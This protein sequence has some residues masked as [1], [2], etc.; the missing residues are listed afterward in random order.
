MKKLFRTFLLTV[1]L[2]PAAFAQ[3]S[4][5]GRVIEA[6]DGRTIVLETSAG[7]ITAQVKN[8]EL[9]EPNQPLFAVT[10]DCLSKLVG[11]KF[12]E[13]KLSRLD[14]GTTIGR[15]MV[16]GVDLSLQMIRDGAAWHEPR[17]TSAHTKA[18]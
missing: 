6:I 1:L 8:L 9:P 17:E 7:K 2:A 10:R 18:E 12:V 3:A 5:T 14:R 15:V 4:L 16:D 13:F 11:D